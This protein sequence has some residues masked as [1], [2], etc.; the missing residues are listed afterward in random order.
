MNAC[1]H[2]Y[3]ASLNFISFLFLGKLISLCCVS[4]S[5]VWLLMLI[6]LLSCSV[7]TQDLHVADCPDWGPPQPALA[8]WA[9]AR[10]HARQATQETPQ[11][12]SHL[13]AAKQQMH[14]HSLQHR[15]PAVRPASLPLPNAA[16]LTPP[17]AG[18]LLLQEESPPT[19]R[20]GGRGGL[21]LPGPAGQ[22][23]VIYQGVYKGIFATEF[24][25]Q[26]N[27]SFLLDKSSS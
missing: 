10:Q 24:V 27:M 16:L 15:V 3:F 19:Q 1:H 17:G 6:D 8:G 9:P 18:H 20:T 23:R 4:V 11:C 5:P 14:L 7:A 12:V 22:Q 26:Q 21:C 25:L 13:Q 2:F